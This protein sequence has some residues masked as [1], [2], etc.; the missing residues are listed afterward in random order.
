VIEVFVSPVVLVRLLKHHPVGRCWV[1]DLLEHY[2][3]D[4]WDQSNHREYHSCHVGF[5]G[6]T[7]VPDFTG[8]LRL[9]Y[10]GYIGGV[11]DHSR[12]VIKGE[13]ENTCGEGEPVPVDSLNIDLNANYVDHH[14]KS[15]AAAEPMGLRL[16]VI[17]SRTFQ[18]IDSTEVSSGSMPDGKYNPPPEDLK[19]EEL[20]LLTSLVNDWVLVDELVVDVLVN[21]VREQTLPRSPDGVVHSREHVREE[22]LATVAVAGGKPDFSEHKQDVLVE[23]VAH[24]EGHSAISPATVNEN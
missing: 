21:H 23:V 16:A 12:Y 3:S 11:Q 15:N 22:H 8:N 18:S 7:S 10:E 24:E 14:S 4:V 1:E 17:I 9:E 5:R 6:H 20:A 2:V 19:V 13:A